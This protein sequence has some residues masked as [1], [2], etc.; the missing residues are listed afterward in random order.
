MKSRLTVAAVLACS[1]LLGCDRKPS[2]PVSTSSTPAQESKSTGAIPKPIATCEAADP[3]WCPGNTAAP[4]SRQAAP[5][6]AQFQSGAVFGQWQC[7]SKM[8]GEE[9]QTFFL[10]GRDGLVSHRVGKIIQLTG[11][12]LRIQGSQGSA[13][14]TEY[15]RD[16]RQ[17]A[18]EI[19]ASFDFLRA[20]PGR[21]Q[22]QMRLSGKMQL[23]QA[24]DCIPMGAVSSPQSQGS[25]GP[26]L[27]RA[28]A[29]AN[30]LAVEMERASHP[31]CRA[32]ASN[33]RMLGSS[34]APEEIRMR[35]VDAMLSKVPSICL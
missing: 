29:Y 6:Q 2:T 1:F 10:F 20:E 26:S 33:I 27:D 21:L 11:Y 35:Q 3:R 8:S 30:N 34:S 4:P 31:A 13:T 12:D 23:E 9:E 17:I 22:F 28:A 32:L 18:S 19:T 7:R 15:T 16:N 14:F 5:Q 25:T 24:V